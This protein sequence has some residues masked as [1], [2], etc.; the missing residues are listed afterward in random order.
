[1]K[2]STF[3]SFV[4]LCLLQ[5][6]FGQTIKV[7]GIVKDSVGV[8]LDMAN[9]IAFNLETNAMENY[10]ITDPRGEYHLSLPAKFKYE[11]KVSYIGFDTET[12]LVDLT[13][14]TKK[15]T[16]DVLLKE[17]SNLL[18]EVEIAYEM[19]VTIKGDTIV[20]NADSFKNGTEQ[21]LGDVLDKLPGVVVNEDG[22]IEVEGKKVTKVMVEGKDFFDGDSKIAV[23]NIPANALSKIEVLRNYN[24][25]SQM[26]GVSNNEDNIAINIRL[27]EGKDKFWFGEVTAGAGADERYLIHPKVF[28]YSPK[29]SINL[30]TDA[31]NIGEVPF[32]TRDYYRFTGGFRNVSSRG[33]TSFN[34]GSNGIGLSTLQNNRA[35]DIN[36]KFLAS[37]FSHK[38]NDKLDLSGFGIYSGTETEMEQTT[39]KLFRD[40]LNTEKVSS[41]TSQE[42]D[43]TL[44]KLSAKYQPSAN[45][46][47]DYDVF[48]KISKQ[49]QADSLSSDTFIDGNPNS[50]GI[51]T[52]KEDDPFVF[53]Q[54]LNIY[55]TINDKNILAFEAQYMAQKERPLFNSI[56]DLLNVQEHLSPYLETEE[57]KFNL[58]QNKITTTGKFDAKLN[59][60][61]V[62]NAKSHLNFTLGTLLST[63]NFNSDLFQLLDDK[64]VNNFTDASFG[65]DVKFQFSDFF[66][67]FH[68]KFITGKFTF[69]PGVKLH[70]YKTVDRQLATTN[71][72]NLTKLLP[73]FYANYQFKQSESLRFRY[74][75][76]NQFTD[77]NKLSEGLLFN[78]YNSVYQGN[79]NLESAIY[80][81][82]SLS[83]FSFIMYNYT[84]INAS[85]SYNKKENDI[86]NSTEFN[87][88]GQVAT[89]QN[90][91]L[92]DETLSSNFRYGRTFRKIKVNLKANGSL[93]KF[94]NFRTNNAG[95]TNLLLNE[96]TSYNYGG[97]VGTNFNNA[98][99]IKVGYTKS[100]NDYGDRVF[101]TDKPYVNVDALFLKHFIFTADYEYFDYKDKA[102]TISNH[103]G[104]LKADLTFRKKGSKWEYRISG[105]NLLQTNSINRDNISEVQNSISTIEYFVQPRYLMFTLKYNI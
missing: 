27:K 51:K 85:I 5:V 49:Q 60:F 94:Y 79:R 17:A 99:N 7:S 48:L 104:F 21:K 74:L 92:P 15:V 8:G 31:N 100:I 65:N 24:E 46:Q 88:V 32:T 71:T 23:Q 36:T 75:M 2:K 70:Q 39:N 33:G 66:A 25:V 102:E 82:Y 80:H 87:G 44:L 26:K 98:P 14:A 62:L 50:N 20:Y 95:E 61:Y 56:S 4:F 3:L 10:A 55:K 89:S 30:L 42:S 67:G 105:T 58:T 18:N 68:Y 103:Y 37:N 91:N 52:L 47:L 53:T 69:E 63:Q 76:T 93:S 78:N 16:Q 38:P 72:N 40:N 41:T 54:N 35:K 84:N 96:V 43:L 101:Y 34:V 13:N 22:E 77:I 28:Y 83:Y 97:D 73:D 6:T 59:Y 1:M 45:Y 19:P 64:T 12:I 86:K 90:S 57:S 81:S 11:L 9:V 29:T